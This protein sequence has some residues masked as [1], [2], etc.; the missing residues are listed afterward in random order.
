MIA[1]VGAIRPCIR[2]A[3]SIVRSSPVI[4]WTS[5]TVRRTLGAPI[6]RLDHQQNKCGNRWSSGAGRIR[7]GRRRNDRRWGPP[8]AATIYIY[9]PA[10]GPGLSRADL[11][12]QL[13]AF[14]ASAAE[15]V[16]SG[17]AQNGFNL[18]YELA[19]GED[20]NQWADSLLKFLTGLGVRAGTTFDAFP[21]AWEEGMAFR[22]VEVWGNPDNR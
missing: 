7:S 4:R 19:D 11:E 17:A 9:C 21:D 14:F 5:A 8:L 18:D 6:L 13:D 20:V 15:N 22:R 2:C 16:G 3:C 12:E 10:D 1:S